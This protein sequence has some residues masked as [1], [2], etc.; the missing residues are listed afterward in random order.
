VAYAAIVYGFMPLG[1]L[2]HP[3]IRAVFEAHRF[4]IYS[5]IFGSIVALT[6]GP[7][8][9]S[10]RLRSSRISLHRWLG[11]LY[12]GV[13]VLIG[14]LPGLYMASHAFGGFVA[15]LGF[16]CL[17]LAWLYSGLRAYLA[18]RAGRIAVHRVW[19]VRNFALTFAAVTLRLYLPAS[20]A[21]G[22][23]FEIAYPYIAWACWV[24]NL[25]AA[26]LL[27]NRPHNPPMQRPRSAGGLDH[28][29]RDAK[30]DSVA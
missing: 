9:F 28:R 29:D 23:E 7:L 24:P 15:R 3:D 17:A 16:A 21:A 22:I 8:Q 19:M 18:I 10:T 2:V 1:S 27:F 14:G 6:L 30:L 12:L 5:H 4:G 13:G 25:I 20:M 11:R 26:E